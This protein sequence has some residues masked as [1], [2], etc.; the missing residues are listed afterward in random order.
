LNSLRALSD[1]D[2]LRVLRGV[3]ESDDPLA[4]LASLQNIHRLPPVLP[5]H[6][7]N[8]V[9]IPDD[10]LPFQYELLMQ[11]PCA[12]PAASP[13]VHLAGDISALEPSNQRVI[14]T[15]TFKPDP[16]LANAQISR[17]TT[18]SIDDAEARQ[19][20]KH[21]LETDHPILGL[22]DADLFLEDFSTYTPR[23]CSEFL[24]NCI[25]FWSCVCLLEPR[26]L[27]V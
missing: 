19:L 7:I 10:I 17:W 22:F 3:T 27:C 24:V 13:F 15:D 18:V 12:Y 8:G 16:R 14:T 1:I 6:A 25:L 23:F 20:I 5:T 11:H 21:Y 2:A 26:P 9:S 4:T